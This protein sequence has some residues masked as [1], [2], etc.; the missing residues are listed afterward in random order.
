MNDDKWEKQNRYFRKEPGKS[1]IDSGNEL[2]PAA[3]N[4]TGTTKVQPQKGGMSIIQNWAVQREAAKKNYEA[5]I[6]IMRNQLDI[7][8]KTVAMQNDLRTREIDARYRAAVEELKK[9]YQ[10]LIAELAI[11]GNDERNR[12]RK[13]AFSQLQRQIDEADEMQL[14]P[15]LKDDLVRRI[16]ED[17]SNLMETI[18][19]DFGHRI[20]ELGKN[21]R[22][23]S[24][25]MGL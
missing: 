14:H 21:V 20:E 10:N 1:E 19:S 23:S 22:D 8:C 5:A 2:V 15:S 18:D 24:K 7:I 13:R 25:E 16:R 3:G 11:A 4:L 9:T 12:I 17:F 6:I